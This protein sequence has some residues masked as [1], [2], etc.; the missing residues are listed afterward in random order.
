MM[1]RTNIRFLV[2][3]IAFL[4]TSCGYRMSGMGVLR[5]GNRLSILP[6]SKQ[7][8]DFILELEKRKPAA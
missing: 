5:K 6:L 7:Q 2:F 4:L 8:W 3:S 1:K